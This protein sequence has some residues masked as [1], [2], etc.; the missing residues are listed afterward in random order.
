MLEID[1]GT[2]HGFTFAPNEAG[3]FYATIVGASPL[4]SQQRY[5]DGHLHVFAAQRTGAGDGTTLALRVDGKLENMMSEASYA[6]D[7]GQ[8][9][10]VILGPDVAISEVIIVRGPLADADTKRLESHLMSKYGLQ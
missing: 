4:V 1:P 2:D 8:L 7:L 5:D 6:H 3:D 9:A 10:G